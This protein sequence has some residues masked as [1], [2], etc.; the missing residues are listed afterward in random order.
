M[1]AA[2]THFTA[3]IGEEKFDSQ[4]TSGVTTRALNLSEPD[5]SDDIEVIFLEST[6]LTKEQALLALEAVRQQILDL[7]WLPA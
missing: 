7:D 4:V 5:N 6:V 2:S 3:K 1:A